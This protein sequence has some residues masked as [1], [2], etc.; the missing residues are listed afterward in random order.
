M[1]KAVMAA[2]HAATDTGVSG[3]YF[4]KAESAKRISYKYVER[5]FEVDNS[6]VS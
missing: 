4:A 3:I 1:W 5:F 6:L 2:A